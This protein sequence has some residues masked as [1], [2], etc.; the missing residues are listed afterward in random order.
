MTNENKPKKVLTAEQKWQK[1]Q[2]Y[3]EYYQRKKR[4]KGIVTS[5]KRGRKPNPK[6]EP[7]KII[8][9]AEPMILHFE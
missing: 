6:P 1:K 3:R 5:D 8:R 9:L 7:I 2:Y 4:E